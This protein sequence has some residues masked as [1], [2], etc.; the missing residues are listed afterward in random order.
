MGDTTSWCAHRLSDRD[1]RQ[2]SAKQHFRH[3][4]AAAATPAPHPATTPF[5]APSSDRPNMSFGT[6]RNHSH[7]CTK[8][9]PTR[10]PHN[11]SA[12]LRATRR[13]RSRGARTTN[14]ERRQPPTRP[15]SG[16]S[17][18]PNLT[19][20]FSPQHLTFHLLLFTHRDPGG[21][22]GGTSSCVMTFPSTTPPN[23]H[24][25]TVTSRPE[26]DRAMIRVCRAERGTLGL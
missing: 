5:H 12:S 4:N 22:Q 11:S 9:L 18:P 19:Y 14:E 2:S 25:Q 1:F 6:Q 23:S 8:V 26:T 15:G 3:Q 24:S 20:Y 17:P 21:P 13:R 7:L 16:P 10:N